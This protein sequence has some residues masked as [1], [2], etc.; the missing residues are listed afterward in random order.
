[1]RDGEH[2]EAALLKRPFG[3]VMTALIGLIVSAISLVVFVLDL[4]VTSEI[5]IR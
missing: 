1:M 3:T 4:L 5:A 2:S